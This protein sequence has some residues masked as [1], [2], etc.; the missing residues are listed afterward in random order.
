MPVEATHAVV[1][2]AEV[3][4]LV[5]LLL[6]LLEL[7]QPAATSVPTAATAMIT[8]FLIGYAPPNIR[9]PFPLPQLL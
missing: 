7:L 2:A 9:D 8:L 3:L 1:A 5:L 4:V 6:L